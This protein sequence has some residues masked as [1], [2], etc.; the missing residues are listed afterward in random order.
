VFRLPDMK[1]TAEVRLMAEGVEVPFLA[2]EVEG[3]VDVYTRG[4]L[5]PGRKSMAG[6][7]V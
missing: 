7:N 5:G 4:T 6:A 3:R 1:F 2:D